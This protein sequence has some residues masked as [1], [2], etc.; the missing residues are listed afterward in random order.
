MTATSSWKT[1]ISIITIC[2][3]CVHLNKTT[4]AELVFVYHFV[5]IN[6]FTHI[7]IPG[8]CSPPR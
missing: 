3:I 5:Y 4:T 6:S 2:Y 8:K 1:P 7:L